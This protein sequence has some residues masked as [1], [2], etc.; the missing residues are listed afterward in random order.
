MKNLTIKNKLKFYFEE[1]IG[2]KDNFS[3]IKTIN[4]NSH[5]QRN[6]PLI[7]I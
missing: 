4:C 3:I 6:N 2:G 1:V 5:N 7:R